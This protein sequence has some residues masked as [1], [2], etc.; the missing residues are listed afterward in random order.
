MINK[1]LLSEWDYE[2]NTISPKQCEDN[3]DK[4]VWWKC[5]LGHTWSSTLNH[6]KQESGCPYCANVKVW[7]GYNDFETNYPMLAK[8]WNYNR[9]QI[10]PS[11]VSKKSGKKV[12]WKCTCGHEWQAR[13]Q[14]RVRGNSCPYCS[15]KKPVRG[16]ND[17][18]TLR[19][20]I[21]KEWNYMKNEKQPYE[22]L[23]HSGKK[24]WWKCQYGH[25]W[26]ATIDSRTRNGNGCPFCAGQRVISGVNDLLTVAPEIAKFWDYERN[27][28][29][30]P[31]KICANSGK[32]V[33]WKCKKGHTWQ[34]SPN[35]RMSSKSGCKKCSSELRTSF[36]EQA[37][38]FYV[39]QVFNSVKSRYKITGMMELDIFI[40]DSKIGIEYDGI[41]YHSEREAINREKR[42]DKYCKENGIR[43]IRIKETKKSDTP[44]DKD[45]IYRILQN[46]EEGLTEVL[47]QLLIKLCGKMPE[48]INVDIE[49]DRNLILAEYVS[50]DNLKTDN[51]DI[52]LREWDYEKNFPLV[53]NML[54]AGSKKKVWWKCQKG[55]SWQ[56]QMLHRTKRKQ[57]TSCPYC[58]NK[59][60]M[61][62]FNDLLTTN[63]SLAAQWNYERNAD[64]SPKNFTEHSGKKVWW[65]CEKGHEWEASITKRS[66]GRGCPICSGKKVIRGINDFG[67]VK[68][69]L[70][71][72]WDFER[73]SL[74]PYTLSRGSNKKAWWKCQYGHN[75]EATIIKRSAGRGCPICANLK[76]SNNNQKTEH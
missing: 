62:G 31:D 33:W 50:D 63:K 29:L 74:N 1:D 72:E 59:K 43:L 76:K 61:E 42:K 58:A 39:S 55:H 18:E 64:L 30:T 27:G 12:W 70:L 26:E 36:P 56:A 69:E 19:K 21:A 75:W 48:N 54:F 20:E 28:S 32:K 38:F 57:A 35:S 68:P 2:K 7:Y 13:V 52:I 23:E 3:L 67:T 51:M 60:V 46:K 37:I 34:V 8:E 66:A 9:N 45:C 15:G 4:E 44:S 24:V 65:K 47:E 10:A 40:E 17:L 16:V 5:S 41:L 73:N 49:R 71:K 11:E 25:E 53:P 6:R 22:Y 14:D